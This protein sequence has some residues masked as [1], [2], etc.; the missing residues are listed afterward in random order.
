MSKF[1]GFV[2]FTAGIAI[3]SIST[4]QYAK[5]KYEQLAEEEIES[6]KAA[7][8]RKKEN[9]FN[10]VEQEA[11]VAAKS[12]NNFAKVMKKEGYTNYSEKKGVDL[13]MPYVIAPDNFGELDDFETVSLTYYSGDDILAD[14]EDEIVENIDELIGS[15]ALN[16][17]GEYEDDSVFVRNEELKCDYEI[18]LD[19]R[20]YS[21]VVKSKPGPVI[22]E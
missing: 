15:D 11:K 14:E 7:F 22:D 18:L 12:M 9:V 20:K 21:E 8:S 19:N 10:K 1:S 2:I 16:S 4:W 6:V 17:F 13:K 5:R 3:G